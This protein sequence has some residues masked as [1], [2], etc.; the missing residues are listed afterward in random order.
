[1]NK[2]IKFTFDVDK[3]IEKIQNKNFN[4]KNPKTR[5]ANY[6]M[7]Y[8][9][10]QDKLIKKLPIQYRNKKGFCIL[11]AIYSA[12]PFLF[13]YDID[14]LVKFTINN[15]KHF[16]SLK[17]ISDAINIKNN[18]LL[19]Y[20][21]ENIYKSYDIFKNNILQGKP[22][23]VEYHYEYNPIVKMPFN[24]HTD[25]HTIALFGYND[26][27]I[28][29]KENSQDNFLFMS[30]AY[31]IKQY[32]DYPTNKT[33]NK[34]INEYLKETNE[35]R[36]IELA[37]KILGYNYDESIGLDMIKKEFLVNDKYFHDIV[38]MST[39]TKDIDSYNSSIDNYSFSLSSLIN[40]LNSINF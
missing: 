40:R 10:K 7:D 15:I 31:Y 1:M 4:S 32:Y 14:T 35:N 30:L 3:V 9:I 6:S 8:L 39:Y 23:V 20:A 22:V 38:N 18:E 27:F 13:E 16:S 12:Y 2:F 11:S 37:K 36:C 26:D 33:D 24:V 34:L 25:G 21:D 17:K 19:L 29:Y 5:L 28:F